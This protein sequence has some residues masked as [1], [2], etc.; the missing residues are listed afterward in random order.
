LPNGKTKSVLAKET[1]LNTIK[2]DH[3]IGHF[4][5]EM[6]GMKYQK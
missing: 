3:G 4:S 2:K 5:Q 6:V 1:E